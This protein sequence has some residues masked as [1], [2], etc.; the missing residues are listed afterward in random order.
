[1][2]S[3][4]TISNKSIQF[5]MESNLT[6]QANF[7]TNLFLGMVG[8]YNGL[9]AE[10]DG[11]T[12]DTAGMMNNIVVGPKGTYSGK[13]KLG[14]H[15]YS[16]GGKFDQSGHGRDG[17]SRDEPGLSGFFV[18]LDLGWRSTPKRITGIVANSNGAWASPFVANLSSNTLGSSAFTML[19]PPDP[20]TSP[21]ASPGGDGYATITNRDGKI[22]VVGKLADGE[23]FAQ[24]VPVAEGGDVPVYLDLYE[25]TGLLT[26]WIN[27]ASRPTGTLTWIKKAS[28]DLYPIGFSNRVAVIGS[29]YTNV[30]PS[31]SLSR[32]TLEI[33]GDGEALTFNVSLSNNKI[34]VLSGSATNRLTG[35]IQPKT[36]LLQ[37][38]FGRTRGGPTMTPAAG[39]LLQN[40]NRAGG[41]FV[42]TNQ[43]GAIRLH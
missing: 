37:L 10:S 15:G 24:T 34:G 8:T 12:A 42:G 1:T 27:L 36:G 2:G 28:T 40:S 30:T 4:G 41:F 11:V 7:V 26:G 13:I 39:A 17:V 35:T 18:N 19:L 38:K 32:G 3:L 5:I 31:L 16:I 25:H 14:G 6:I 33:L 43:A 21:V 23:S 9:F 29:G 22:S 20:N